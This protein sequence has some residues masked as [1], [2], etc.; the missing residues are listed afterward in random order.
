MALSQ[1]SPR[2][3]GTAAVKQNAPVVTLFTGLT[4][5]TSDASTPA[6][7]VAG[8]N[9]A[10]TLEVH[11]TN[12]G[13]CTVSVQ[14]TFDEYGAA[15]DDSSWTTVQFKVLGTASPSP[16][17]TAAVGATDPTTVVIAILDAYP[18]IRLNLSSVSGT[19]AVTARAYLAAQ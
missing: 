13:T 11:K 1:S 4:A 18:T 14:G 5:N 19:L 8:M 15:T 6:L 17:T 7:D 3:G 12:T 16:A 2:G 9:G 10:I